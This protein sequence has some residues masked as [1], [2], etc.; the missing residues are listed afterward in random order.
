MVC[1]P[2]HRESGAVGS[3]AVAGDRSIEP[4]GVAMSYI[5]EFRSKWNLKNPLPSP[6]GRPVPG[7]SQGNLDSSFD[8]VG[9]YAAFIVVYYLDAN[10]ARACLPAH[11]ELQP[12]IGSPSGKHP[13]MCS[14][15]FQEFCCA[16]R[17]VLRPGLIFS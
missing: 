11:L 16:T 3:H 17:A 8:I 5:D 4:T 10:V 15:G 14:W 1:P 2:G 9:Q 12:S 6:V 7:L 13:V